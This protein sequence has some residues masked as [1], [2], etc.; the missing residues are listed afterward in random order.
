MKDRKGAGDEYD[1]NLKDERMRI[2]VKWMEEN[3]PP[4]LI[5]EPE[6]AKAG[7]FRVRGSGRNESRGTC[8]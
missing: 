5:P 6:Y 3:Y 2:A 1:E 8:P 4:T 7:M